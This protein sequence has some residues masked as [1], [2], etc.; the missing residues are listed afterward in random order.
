MSINHTLIISWFKSLNVLHGISILQTIYR[1][2]V[3][4]H[5]NIIRFCSIL[6]IFKFFFAIIFFSNKKSKELFY[7]V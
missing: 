6:E 2:E 1:Y 3:E 7:Y 5:T 4:F